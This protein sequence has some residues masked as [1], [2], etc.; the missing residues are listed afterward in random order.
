MRVID[1]MKEAM[2]VERVF[3]ELLIV[4]REPCGTK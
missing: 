4:S 2:Y 1:G 3:P